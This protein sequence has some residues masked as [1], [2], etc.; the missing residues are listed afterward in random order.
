[1]MATKPKRESPEAKSI[2]VSDEISFGFKY[3]QPASYSDGASAEFLV[4]FLGR[5]KGLCGLGW[6]EI[7]KSSRHSYGCEKIPVSSIKKE[8]GLTD[9]VRHLLAF[10][11]T[12]DKHVFLGFRDG[13][14]FQIVFIEAKFGDIYDH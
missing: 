13:N 11:A 12:G 5:L 4:E 9:D 7:R 10:R 2:S 1:M 3:L 6:N 14:V 8:T